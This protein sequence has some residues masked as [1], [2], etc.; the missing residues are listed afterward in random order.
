MIHT[1]NNAILFISMADISR[2][3]IR[4]LWAHRYLP[5]ARRAIKDHVRLIRKGRYLAEPKPE[6]TQDAEGRN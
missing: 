2:K 5:K 3:I 1:D 4:T 6:F